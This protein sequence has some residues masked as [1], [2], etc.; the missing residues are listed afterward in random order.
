[1]TQY[2][3]LIANQICRVLY[4]NNSKIL[5]IS[6]LKLLSIFGWK[7]LYRVPWFFHI[8]LYTFGSGYE[9]GHGTSSRGYLFNWI[10]IWGKNGIYIFH[11]FIQW[12]I[13]KSFVMKL[14]KIFTVIFQFWKIEF[15]EY[16]KKSFIFSSW[17]KKS[18]IPYCIFS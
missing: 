17:T 16:F 8:V 9:M 7:V 4:I 14:H 18:H 3:L 10:F 6:Q 1:M 2:Y 15:H 11:L 5:Y 12:W 13:I